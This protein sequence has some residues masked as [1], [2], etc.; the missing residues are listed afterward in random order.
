MQQYLPEI[1]R[2]V[3][4]WTCFL[5]CAASAH[6]QGGPSPVVVSR[7]RQEVVATGQTFVGTV[8]PAKT[9]SVGSAV[10]GRVV[11]YPIDIGVRVGKGEP[12]CKLLTETI[13]LQIAA[14]EA[15]LRLRKEELR[16]LQNGM[17]P[18]EVAMAK[19]RMESAHALNEF[20]QGRY[21][22]AEQ[23]VLERK[24]LTQEQL[25]EFL[26]GS[27]AAARSLHAAEQ[28]YQ[29]MSKGPREESIA[30]AQARMDAQG[31]MVQQLKDQLRKHTMISPFDGYVVAKRT[32]VGE[33]VMRSQVVAEIVYMDEIEVEAHVLDAQV[34]HVRLGME[35][36]VEVSALEQ[37][38][39]IGTVARVSPQ[40]DVKS[41]TFPVKVRVQNIIREDGPV[42]KAGMLARVTLPV[43]RVRE[44]L[45][46]P[47]D[48]VVFG[49]PSPM[50]YVVVS[51]A[52]AAAPPAGAPPKGAPVPG[53][54]APAE[55]DIVKPV[56]VELGVASANMLEVKADLKA[57]DRVVVLGNERLRP[58]AAVKILRETDALP[59]T[60]G[61]STDPV[62][63]PQ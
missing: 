60:D 23:L 29:M 52:A 10:D 19:A 2:L 43:G 45:L 54:G 22:R 38:L 57:S 36:R 50:V 26:S 39:Y 4:A 49:G 53:L 46:V 20:A 1:R 15:E 44:S 14:A 6:A 17:R 63:A 41:R 11:E 61:G 28:E 47:K 8:M 58:G 16:E 48:A 42:L 21:K 33:W 5:A 13:N 40:A 51:V 25:E 24:T 37:P 30:Q 7:V 31:E 34:D 32:E 12:L 27:I 35:A 18:E 9:S 3:T 62:A 59:V 55:G 56:P